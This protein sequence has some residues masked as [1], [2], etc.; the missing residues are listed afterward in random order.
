MITNWQ[1]IRKL[2]EDN[3]DVIFVREKVGGKWGNYSLRELPEALRE[4]H[5]QRFCAENREPVRMLES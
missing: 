3:L 2:C 1:R 4:R 5:I